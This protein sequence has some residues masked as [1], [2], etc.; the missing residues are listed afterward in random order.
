MRKFLLIFTALLCSL[1]PSWAAEASYK[2]AFNTSSTSTR[3]LNEITLMNAV[4]E[5]KD[6]IRS[7]TDLAKVYGGGTG[8]GIKLATGSAEGKF[9]IKLS[10]AG[11]Q[12]ITRIV[13]NAKVYNV[14]DGGK[15][16]IGGTTSGDASI[17]STTFTDY[18]F[19]GDT[20]FAWE[21]S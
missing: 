20:N 3:E 4:T 2:I 7:F 13:V 11:K 14:S 5:G 12:K 8:K 19:K 1:L 15:L 18:E 17:S 21:K 16:K 9:S 10:A 6:Y